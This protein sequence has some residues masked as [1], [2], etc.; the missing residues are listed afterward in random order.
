MAMAEAQ[1]NPA[2]HE[3]RQQKSAAV[4]AYNAVVADA[5]LADLR[6]TE[7]RFKIQKS[8][9]ALRGRER[10]IRKPLTKREFDSELVA[11]IYSADKGILAG[12]FKWT[13]DV[14]KGKQKLVFIAAT[15]FILYR[16]VPKVEEEHAKAFLA[17]VGRFAT[18]PYFRA[19][20]AR[21]SAEA[22]ADLPILPVLR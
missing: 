15:Y 12:E 13:V 14:R 16:N 9:Y 11:P 6:L 4:L 1:E 7:S 17:R 18:Y 20:V 19:L 22:N 3:Q 21:L 8:F 10:E 2:E 5:V